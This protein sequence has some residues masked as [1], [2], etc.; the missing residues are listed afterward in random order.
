MDL[1]TAMHRLKNPPQAEPDFIRS[2]VVMART[3]TRATEFQAATNNATRVIG[4]SSLRVGIGFLVGAGAVGT[5]LV[6]PAMFPLYAVGWSV[7]PTTPRWFGLEEYAAVVSQEWYVYNG[8][9]TP[10]VVLEAYKLP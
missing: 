6:F 8:A 5:P 10:L 4:F 1:I 3:A 2:G 7:A 9:T